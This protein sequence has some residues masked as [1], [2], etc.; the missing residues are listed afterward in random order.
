MQF[1]KLHINAI[2]TYNYKI[3][4]QKNYEKKI[5]FEKSSRTKI[6]NRKQNSHYLYKLKLKFIIIYIFHNFK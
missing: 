3:K 2:N 4:K 6:N 1:H 5:Y